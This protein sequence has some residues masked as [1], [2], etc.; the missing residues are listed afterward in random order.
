MMSLSWPLLVKG[1]L[2]TTMI[3]SVMLPLTK[4][5][6]VGSEQVPGKGKPWKNTMVLVSMELRE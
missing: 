2:L 5:T 6:G 3:L 1:L 4:W